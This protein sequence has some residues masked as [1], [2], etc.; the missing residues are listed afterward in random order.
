MFI[1][2]SQPPPPP[3]PTESSHNH[4]HPLHCDIKVSNNIGTYRSFCPAN[5]LP[6]NI[7]SW[8]LFLTHRFPKVLHTEPEREDRPFGQ[9]SIVGP[10]QQQQHQQL[11]TL[12]HG[13]A[14]H[15]RRNKTYAPLPPSIQRRMTSRKLELLHLML[16]HKK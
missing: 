6:H 4:R 1:N 3:P 7:P 15:S 13:Q 10:Q 12:N 5:L 2:P 9:N 14:N 8:E 16:P 11:S